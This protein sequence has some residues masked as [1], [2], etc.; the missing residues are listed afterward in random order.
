MQRYHPIPPPA[1]PRRL[2]R[3]DCAFTLIELLV[4]LS[5]VALLAALLLPGLAKSKAKAEALNCSN[6]LK[7]LGFAWL[8]YADENADQ[9]VNN[10]GVP[11]T[12][13]RRQNW[14]NDVLDWECSDDNT[15]LVYLTEGKLGP[16]ANRASG[17]YKC[18]ADRALA[19]N[20]T[21]VRSYS[22]NAMVGN[23]GELTNRFNPLYQQFFKKSQVPDPSGMFVFLDEHAD[24]LNDGFFVNRLE[25][26]VWGN[27]PGSYHN[28]GANLSFVDGH[29]AYHHWEVSSTV[30]PVLK[31][32]IDAFPAA[33]P[34]DFEWLKTR[35][36]LKRGG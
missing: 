24:T 31:T 22:L 11:E 26:Y 10:H 8:L 33:P 16:Y 35:T 23:P 6:N 1:R 28:N 18:P 17:I 2:C 21:R 20:G 30:R 29:V 32:R 12:L 7:Q 19:P 4:A 25:D 5:I 9:L 14:V 27:V 36:S 13:T 3:R 15:N 34:A